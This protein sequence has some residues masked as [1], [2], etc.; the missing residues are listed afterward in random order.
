MTRVAPASLAAPRTVPPIAPDPAQR[1]RLAAT[2]LCAVAVAGMIVEWVLR[3]SGVLRQLIGA[4]STAYVMVAV[5]AR[6]DRRDYKKWVVGGLGLC[7]LGDMIGPKHF[8]AGVVMFLLAHCAL[9]IAFAVAGLNRQR[10]LGSLIGA[11][12]IG[13]VVA[14]A[15]V[16][17]VPEAQRPFI[18]AYSA[19]LTLMLG[20]AGGTLGV[21]SRGLVPLAA[22]LF[23]VSDLCLAQTAFVGGGVG[24][25]IVGYPTYYTACVL[26][27]WSINEGPARAKTPKVYYD[28]A[29]TH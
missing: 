20:F 2:V 15:I 17:R 25:T 21:G 24:W 23:Y 4:A 8:L 7:W 6:G 18:W 3:D 5:A 14:W 12:A 13:S 29:C 19:I 27:A 16:P 1:V 28:P 26:F 9:I 10:L 11:A 22:V